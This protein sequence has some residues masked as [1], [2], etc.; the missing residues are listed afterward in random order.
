MRLSE[1]M[2]LMIPETLLY[3]LYGFVYVTVVFPAR[4]WAMVSLNDN[5]WGTSTRN[6]MNNNISLDILSILLWNS[7]LVSG[8]IKNIYFSRNEQI[9]Q[10][11]FLIGT[12][13]F[14]VIFSAFVYFY[15]YYKYFF[16]YFLVLYPLNTF[17]IN[18][19]ILLS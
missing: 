4:L 8:F 12:S 16:S 1:A 14:Y 18:I 9:S 10:F 7:A 3:F 11:Y 2:T 13:G 6:L 19:T 5:S 15:I 17:W